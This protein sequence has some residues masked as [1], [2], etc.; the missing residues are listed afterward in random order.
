MEHAM[1]SPD[2]TGRRPF[3]IVLGLDLTDTKSSGFALDQAA[4]IASRIE[5]SQ[6]HAVYALSED[7]SDAVVSEAAGLTQMYVNEKVAELGVKGTTLGVHVH[8]G[9]P[10]R[11]IAQMASDLGADMIIVGTHKIPHL[12]T[13][14][15]GSTAERVMASAHCP[16][17]VAGPRPPPQPSHVIVIEAPCP[18]CVRRRNE[19]G[20]REFWCEQHTATK[21]LRRH[22]YSYSSDTPF[23]SP[24]LSVGAGGDGS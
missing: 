13:I 24:D 10:A 11:E 5:P 7:A 6:L 2:T 16:V 8:R 1:T 3:I 14:F 19:T 18:D 15:V 4:R 12:K 20:N 9:D 21:F 22:V 23:G 17:L